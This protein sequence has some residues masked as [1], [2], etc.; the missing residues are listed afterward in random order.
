MRSLFRLASVAVLLILALS[1]VPF[2][3]QKAEAATCPGVGGG[4]CS[5]TCQRCYDDSNCPLFWGMQQTCV[6]WNYC[7]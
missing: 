5:D 3:S 7:P 6:C 1:G 4:R 2:G